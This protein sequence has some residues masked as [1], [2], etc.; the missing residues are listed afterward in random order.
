M[1]QRVIVRINDFIANKFEKLT[2]AANPCKI[3]DREVII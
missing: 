1:N 2:T 3:F